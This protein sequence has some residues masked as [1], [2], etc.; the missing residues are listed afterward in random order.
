MNDDQKSPPTE[1]KKPK[2]P[3]SMED[4]RAAYVVEHGAD[5]E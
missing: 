2:P 3:L 5:V 1:E 4:A